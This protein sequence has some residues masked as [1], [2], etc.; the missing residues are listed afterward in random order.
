MYLKLLETGHRRTARAALWLA[1][2][3]GRSPIDDVGKTSLYRPAL[4]G[5]SW[6]A[7]VREVMRG[8]SEWT[9]AERELF[10]AFVSQLNRCTYCADI[11]S[12]LASRGSGDP[13]TVESLARW[14]EGDHRSEIKAVLGF[15]ERA[16]LWPEELTS[17][18]VAEVRAAGVSDGAIEDALHVAFVFNMVNRLADA[19]GFSW[20]SASETD[21]AAQVLHRIGYRLPPFLLR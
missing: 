8:P 12:R 18:D 5:R 21:K 17:A 4:F 14:R 15:L 11:H 3:A 19:F 2:H 9:P 13:V 1:E 16:T 20:R 10:A 7:L 6:L